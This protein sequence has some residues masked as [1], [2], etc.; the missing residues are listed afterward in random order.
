MSRWGRTSDA[1]VCSTQYSVTDL[2]LDGESI[3]GVCDRN[4]ALNLEL[5][6]ARRL[7]V[8]SGLKSLLSSML[9]VDPCKRIDLAAVEAV[10]VNWRV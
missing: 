8:S 6:S 2:A 7:L 5:C 10:L 3:H 4:F 1:L 9:E